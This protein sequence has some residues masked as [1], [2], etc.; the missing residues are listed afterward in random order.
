MS[1][2]NN[3]SRNWQKSISDEK[4]L[5]LVL[6]KD[7]NNQILVKKVQNF[8][9]YS[10]KRNQLITKVLWRWNLTAPPFRGKIWLNEKGSN[11]EITRF[12]WFLAWREETNSDGSGGNFSFFFFMAKNVDDSQ[13][14][15]KDPK[16][17]FLKNA[18]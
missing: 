14:S 4:R 15:K 6:R 2:H 3:V 10:V 11:I 16:S 1:F 7:L 9:S 5:S 13:C 12:F 18:C 17:V 8:P